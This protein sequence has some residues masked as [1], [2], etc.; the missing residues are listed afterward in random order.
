MLA[1]YRADLWGACAV[2]G[3]GRSCSC[4]QRGFQAAGVVALAVEAGGLVKAA[5]KW[6]RLQIVRVLMT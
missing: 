2:G 1:A 5:R 3:S 4:C 6:F